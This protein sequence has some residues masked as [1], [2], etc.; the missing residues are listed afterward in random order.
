M[1]NYRKIILLNGHDE[2]V[3]RFHPWIFSGAVK[4]ADKGIKEGEWVEVYAEDKS[5]LA[6]G[7]ALPGT[8]AVKICSFQQ[9]DPDQQWWNEKINKA[10]LLR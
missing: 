10:Y 5:F 1:G 2:A 6:S 8:I 3:R 7:Y 4:R 9:V